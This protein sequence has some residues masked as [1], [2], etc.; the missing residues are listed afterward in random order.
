MSSCDAAIVRVTLGLA[1]SPTL[2]PE[3]INRSTDLVPTRAVP[4]SVLDSS[5]SILPSYQHS[6][7]LENL[8]AK[9]AIRSIPD[10]L[11]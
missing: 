11:G 9:K 7:C 8:S 3:R 6:R 5:L 2:M 1:C 4:A 10:I